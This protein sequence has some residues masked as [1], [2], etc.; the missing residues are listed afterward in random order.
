MTPTRNPALSV[1][2]A[3]ARH[4]AVAVGAWLLL[5]GL[6]VW[7]GQAVGLVSATPID[8]GSGDSLRAAE[9]AHEAGLTDDA[10]EYVLVGPGPSGTADPSQ[11]R[12]TVDDLAQALAR[13]D[14]VDQVGQAAVPST[15]GTWLL[16]SLTLKGD[17]QTAYQRVDPVRAV[18][19]QVAAAHP[20][21]TVEQTG[22]ASLTQG[23]RDQVHK[24]MAISERLSIPIT[25]AVLVV[26]FGAFVAAVVPVVLALTAV[27]GA[28]GLSAVVSHVVP[29]SGL[30]SNVILLIGMAVGVDY[31][32]F[33]LKREREERSHGAGARRAVE[34]A[35]QTSGHAVVFAGGAVIVSLAGLYLANDTGFLS[36][37][38]SA[39][40][41]VVVAVLGSLTVLPALLMLLSRFLD[42]PRVPFVW[43]ATNQTRQP[44]LWPALLRPSLAHPALTMAATVV[45][46]LAAA[47]PILSLRLAAQQTDEM[48][49]KIP[50]VAALHT[51]NDHFPQVGSSFLVVVRAPQSQ[52]ATVRARLEGLAAAQSADVGA[53][54][55]VLTSADGRT[56]TVAVVAAVD[57]S[58]GA[59]D[60]Y[61]LHLRRTLVPEALRDVPDAKA[62]VGGSTAM[63]Y[64]FAHNMRSRLGWVVGFVLLFNLVVMAS[65]F[66]SLVVGAATLMM[67][68][69][70]TGAAF[71]ALSVV[72]Q[73]HWFDALLGYATT[74]KVISWVPLF[75]FVVLVGLS[76]DY[77]VFVLNRVHEAAQTGVP[78]R[79]A[80]RDG[81]V[82]SSGVV[83]SAAM[84]MVAVFS[85][86]GILSSFQDFIQLTLG[87][88]VAV[89]VDVIVVRGFLLPATLLVLGRWAWWPGPLSRPRPTPAPLAER[90][91]PRLPAWVP[92]R[93]EV[94][95][96]A[97]RTEAATDADDTAG[98]PGTPVSPTPS[99]L[100][101]SA[102]APTWVYPPHLLT[103]TRRQPQASPAAPSSPTRA[104]V[105]TPRRHV[106]PDPD[107]TPVRGVPAVPWVDKPG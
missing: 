48:P 81:I 6:C 55:Q 38:W 101:P 102:P 34:R 32:L 75:L 72:F 76:M 25:L 77:H 20:D 94:R 40:L 22:A 47:A 103:T 92:T 26:V 2:R 60:D 104:T 57:A 83:T 31:S 4:P 69:L 63:D 35:A 10:A 24:D 53:P 93:A 62:V 67:N 54:A 11:L 28:T 19:A 68:L 95:L 46:L 5:V 106:E 17:P 15:D 50:A 71:G 37:A 82:R 65:T 36:L 86:F 41:V 66:R 88:T 73:H 13:N 79:D 80:V 45:V 105:T 18:T 99:P 70:S 43:R 56:S 12:A 89:L 33:Y 90:P 96:A 85:L 100:A 51:M 78:H 14:Q 49:A 23:R 16:L 107:Q 64:D 74:G 8:L 44:R 61:L 52:S 3:S 84:V 39:I 7:A 9:L 29:D 21:V 27:A 87:L 30:T 42:R 98:T 91:S 97:V 58:S 59:A 1:A